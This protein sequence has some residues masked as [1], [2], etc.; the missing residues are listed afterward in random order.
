MN[1]KRFRIAIIVA[2]F[3]FGVAGPLLAQNPAY[4]PW[5]GGE[6][7]DF[8]S[9]LAMF[10]KS[11]PGDV[12][13]SSSKKSLSAQQAHDRAIAHCNCMARFYE[14][15]GS[16]LLVQTATADMSGRLKVDNNLPDEI[17]MALEGYDSI[18]QTCEKNPDFEFEASAPQAPSEVPADEAPK[19]KQPFKPSTN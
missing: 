13:G 16:L 10:E 4:S 15:K 11:C 18:Y 3:C 7:K 19:T 8:R 9:A 12:L 14:A 17:G 6:P 2:I 5:L 1:T